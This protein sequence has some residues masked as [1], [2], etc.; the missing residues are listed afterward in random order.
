MIKLFEEYNKYFDEIQKVNFIESTE[1]YNLPFTQQ[2]IDSVKK[3]VGDTS[4]TSPMSISSPDEENVLTIFNSGRKY[5]KL[6]ACIVKKLDEWFYVE[7]LSYRSEPEIFNAAH[8]YKCDQL[9]G[10]LKCLKDIL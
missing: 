5:R 1:G 8:Y 9:E 10:L 3:G 4:Y 6:E 2:E 7:H